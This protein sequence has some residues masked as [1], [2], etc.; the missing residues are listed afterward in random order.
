MG[1]LYALGAPHDT[2]VAHA[3]DYFKLVATLAHGPP[4]VVANRVAPVRRRQLTVVAPCRLH[5]LAC[6]LFPTV[7]AKN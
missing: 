5:H 2:E 4:L 3:Y 7:A 1:P 6:L